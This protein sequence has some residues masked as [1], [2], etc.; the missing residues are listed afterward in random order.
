MTSFVLFSEHPLVRAFGWSLLH[1]IWEGAIVAVLLAVVLKLLSS[2]SPQP[3]YVIACCALALMAALPLT[4][5]GYLATRPHALDPAITYSVLLKRPAI[6]LHVDFT[7]AADTWLDQIAASLDRC[8]PWILTAWFAGALLFLCRL[9]LGLM[10]ARRM[11]ATAT[12]AA[13][14]ELQQMFQQLKHRLGITRTIKLANSALV[15]VPTVIGWLRP[16]V[17]VPIGCLTGLA[18]NQI[19]AILAH[20]LAHIQRHDYLVSVLQSFTEAVLFYHPAVWWV[21]QQV[22]REREDCCDDLAV[23]TSGD[24]LAYAK[25]LSI[26]EEHRSSYPAISL[27]ANGGA[28]VMRIKRLLG[29]KETPAFSQL[30][31]MT[32]LAVVVAAA[33]CGI[34]TF[35]HAQAATDKQLSAEESAALQSLPPMYRKWIDEDVRWI[36]TSEERAQYLKLPNNDERNEFIKQFWERRNVEVPGGGENSFRAEYYRR[37]AYANRH[38][39]YTD[40][41][42][43]AN[44]PGWKSDR[45][46]IYIVY[47]PPD[48]IDSHP[49]SAGGTKPYV[50]WHYRTIQD[51]VV[52]GHVQGTAEYKAT[53][54]PKKDVDM[55]FVDTCSC[56]NY[57]LQTTPKN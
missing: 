48:E 47:G 19:E 10:V 7:G 52:P 56:G 54:V 21:S 25:A 23:R 12:Q 15:Q 31:G 16:V 35:A 8:L 53:L 5:F 50:V 28:L 33:A 40:Q 34:A 51:Y 22:R 36:I 42:A 1:F 13:S 39:A 4:T 17:L 37:I 11:K 24:S 45:G 57:R 18:P 32:L 55:K 3:R 27:G 46:R 44:V 26:L 29:Y 6:E 49:S 38:L 14:S 41:H 2:R 43:A 30:A 9:N 20:E